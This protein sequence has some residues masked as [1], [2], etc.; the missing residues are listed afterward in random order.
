M[1]DRTIEIRITGKNE[2]SGAL[3]DVT[4]SLSHLGNVGG[5][6][7]GQLSS[8]GGSLGNIGLVA[9][10]VALAGVT[11]LAGGFLYAAKSAL[12]QIA[13]HERLGLAIQNLYARELVR[14]SGVEEM[15]KVGTAQVE[16]SKKEQKELDNLSGKIDN[17]THSRDQLAI[18]IQLTQAELTKMEG[19]DKR[20]EEAI[21]RKRAALDELNYKFNEASEK[22]TEH[23]ARIS[24]LTNKS[25][26]YVDVLQS[27]RTGQISMKEAMGLAAEKSKELLGWIENL[28]AES[29]FDSTDI[30]QAFKTAQVYGFTAEEAKR[31]TQAEVD[32]AAATGAGSEVTKQISLALGQMQAKGKVSGQE[33]IQLSNAGIGTTEILKGMGFSLDDVSK[34]LVNADD[35]IEATM[36]DMEI[37]TGAAK[38][39]A[40]SFAGI[41]STLEEYKN[42]ALREFF[43]GTFEAIRPYVVDFLDMIKE[44]LPSIK[45][46][47]ES[48]GQFVGGALK[49]IVGFI[50]NVKKDG[51]VG[52]LGLTPATSELIK[53]ITGTLS[54]FAGMIM[55][56]L[57]PSLDKLSK[58]G[59]IDLLNKAIIWL[60]DNFESVK[61][62]IAGVL[63][64]LAGSVVIS[65][66]IGL[67]TALSS[68]IVAVIAAAA[69]LGA[70]WA[71]NWFGIRDTLTEVWA[72]VYPILVEVWNWLAVNVPIAI[73][74]LTDFFNNVLYPIFLQVFTQIQEVVNTV[75]TTITAWWTAHGANVM[76]IV[77]GFLTVIGGLIVGALSFIRQFWATWGDT[78]L[79]V[80]K[81][82]WDLIYGYVKFVMGIIG[83]VIDMVAALIKGDWTAFGKALQSNWQLTWDFIMTILGAARDLLFIAIDALII[84]ISGQW[85]A[86]K[87][88]LISIWS[89]LWDAIVAYFTTRKEAIIVLV[90]ELILAIKTAWSAFKESLVTLW[91]AAWDSIVES[92]TTIKE[93]IMSK[94]DSI[95]ESIKSAFSGSSFS[96]IID[97]IVE[98]FSVE[99]F[100]K[101]GD[102]I[103]EGIKKGIQGGWDTI[104]G[105]AAELGDALVA[106]IK[107]TLGIASPSAVFN[108]IGQNLMSG[109]AMGITNG[110]GKVSNAMNSVTT[111]IINNYNFSQVILGGVPSARQ[112]FELMKS[113]ALAFG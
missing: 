18:K 89:V 3:N 2:A 25:A 98:A 48:L 46:W 37:F 104:T 67:I 94:T 10:G 99:S 27:V 56:V 32:F 72:S 47:G 70:A 45:S 64:V 36:K 101:I 100:V 34:G 103:I 53:K 74:T 108:E 9:G 85:E 79:A 16:L 20:N 43:T 1:S 63:T 83:G 7:V 30:G 12:E 6:L 86:F 55:G 61:G 62:A 88:T 97:G 52:A 102:N 5:G 44:G 82:A 113:S 14:T 28:A 22:V 60:N 35:F 8:L 58:G 49:D 50:S 91:N 4:N 57:I 26:G 84:Y 110:E 59:A 111:N 33:L 109:L 105:L 75:L 69:L 65:V 81:V 15:V 112:E 90:T 51:L 13:S 76:V 106:K 80:T 73:Q 17:E 21:N 68:P 78:I 19:A 24:E 95:I 66:V 93:D 11:A 77:N 39:Q 41:T 92:F 40:T 71:G 107:E 23:T 29:P 31:L 96:G 38:E 42:I 54:G 87:S